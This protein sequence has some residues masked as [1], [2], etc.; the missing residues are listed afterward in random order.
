MSPV[1]EIQRVAKRFGQ[2][3]AIRTVDLEAGQVEDV[4]GGRLQCD[5]PICIP[6]A[7]PAG[8][9]VA[10]DGIVLVSDTNNHRIV[11]IDRGAGRYRTFAS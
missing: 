4:D 2:T 8:V 6:L 11:E 7:E 10:Q 5:D 3:E 9:A 1:L